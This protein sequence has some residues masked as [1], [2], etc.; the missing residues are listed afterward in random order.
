[1]LAHRGQGEQIERVDRSRT[2]VGGEFGRIIDRRHDRGTIGPGRQRHGDNLLQFR[3][4]RDGV[5]NFLRGRFVAD[6][7]RELV[8][9]RIVLRIDRAASAGEGHKQRLGFR[10]RPCE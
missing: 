6:R 4:R 9:G 8:A 1:M 7:D 2:A 10:A 5:R 3:V